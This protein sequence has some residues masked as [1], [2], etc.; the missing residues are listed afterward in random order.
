[1]D[2]SDTASVRS[3]SSYQKPSV[4]DEDA[5]A[6]LQSLPSSGRATPAESV[7]VAET[8]ELQDLAATATQPPQEIPQQQALPEQSRSQS[9]T[10]E[11]SV[12]SF[13]QVFQFHSK[14]NHDAIKASLR[15]GLLTMTIPK[16][17]APGV[18]RINVE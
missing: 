14:I 5:V 4:E 12:G 8:A 9:W 10:S 3:T 16:S 1:V 7:D 11:R 15:D 17:Q 2:N 18:R 6:D 13:Q